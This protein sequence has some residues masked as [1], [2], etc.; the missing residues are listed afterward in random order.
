M[1]HPHSENRWR[2]TAI[3]AGDTSCRSSTS[4]AVDC[5]PLW[6][7]RATTSGWNF[8]SAI[9]VCSSCTVQ[10]GSQHGTASVRR[11]ASSGMTC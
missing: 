9:S 5:L 7:T 6:P 2:N 3:W 1:V 11:S 10:W 8:C 4:K